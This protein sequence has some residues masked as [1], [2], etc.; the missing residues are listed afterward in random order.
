[1]K[2]F[3]QVRSEVLNVMQCFYFFRGINVTKGNGLFTLEVICI[4]E[5]AIMDLPQGSRSIGGNEIHTFDNT[6]SRALP[7]K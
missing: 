2:W 5:N 4:Q 6:S 3:F 1:M 7:R